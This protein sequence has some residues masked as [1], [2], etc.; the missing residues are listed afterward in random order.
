ML[1]I[2]KCTASFKKFFICYLNYYPY[3]AFRLKTMSPLVITFKCSAGHSKI[4][5]I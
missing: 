3:P 5:K 2:C 1:V 4:F